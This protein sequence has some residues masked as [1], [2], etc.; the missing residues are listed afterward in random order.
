M[1]KAGESILKGAKE[2]LAYAKGETESGFVVHVPD[3]VDVRGIRQSLKLS[4]EA[5][6]TQFGFSISAVRHWEQGRR[7]PEVAARAYLLVIKNDP[8]AVIRALEAA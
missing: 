2:A 4:Q 8:K 3:D 5:F 6:A 1:T 7:R